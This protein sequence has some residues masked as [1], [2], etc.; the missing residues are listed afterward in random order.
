MDKCYLKRILYVTVAAVVIVGMLLAWNTG[1]N[2]SLAPEEYPHIFDYPYELTYWQIIEQPELYA[3]FMVA[4]YDF[5]DYENNESLK[6]YTGYYLYSCELTNNRKLPESGNANWA[7]TEQNLSERWKK[8]SE[9]YSAFF[10]SAANGEKTMLRMA[11]LNNHGETYIADLIYEPENNVFYLVHDGTRESNQ[12]QTLKV[13]CAE[14]LEVEINEKNG[15]ELLVKYKEKRNTLIGAWMPNC[16]IDP[17][18]EDEI[19]ENFQKLVDRGTG[20]W[21]TG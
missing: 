8:N 10:R 7:M 14:L 4:D 5:A 21:Y 6:R 11:G 18:Y 12:S 1:E 13:I 9:R 3:E 15:V 19:I 2:D 16:R 20:V 17:E